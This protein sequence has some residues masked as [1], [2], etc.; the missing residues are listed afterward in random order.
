[1]RNGPS[2]PDVRPNP[3]F[4]SD[5]KFESGTGWPSFYAPMSED[6]VETEEDRRHGMRRVEVVCSRCNAQ[7]GHL[8]PDGP[9]PTGFRDCSEVRF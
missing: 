9:K 1:M 6:A 2:G 4:E 8:F 3:L 7:L 5:T